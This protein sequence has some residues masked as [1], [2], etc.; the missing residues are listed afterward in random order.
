MIQTCI[1]LTGIY[2]L[3]FSCFFSGW[4]LNVF[5]YCG[6]QSELEAPVVFESFVS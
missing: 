5:Y 6:G 3:V 1:F 2:L 4:G